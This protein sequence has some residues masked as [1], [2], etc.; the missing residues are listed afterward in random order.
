MHSQQDPKKP[1]SYGLK[2][3]ATETVFKG[4]RKKR[5][6]G[7]K[8]RYQQ[9]LSSGVQKMTV[10]IEKESQISAQRSE[11]ILVLQRLTSQYAHGTIPGKM[12]RDRKKPRS[13]VS[14]PTTDHQNGLGTNPWMSN[15]QVR[16]RPYAVV[17]GILLTR[18]MAWIWS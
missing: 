6:Q 3:A 16:K 13:L 12:L 7:A 11:D 4:N 17:Q 10:E 9:N 1:Y 14:F 18:G 15:K 8:A 5:N 2:I